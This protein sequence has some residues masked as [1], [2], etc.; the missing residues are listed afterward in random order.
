MNPFMAT[1]F[2]DSCTFDPAGEPDN[3]CS[4]EIFSYYQK[5]EINLIVSH[6]STKEA[7]YPNI[8]S[9]IKSEAKLSG[10]DVTLTTEENEKKNTIWNI[11][12]DSQNPEDMK[13]D[14]E[15]VFEAHKCGG[16]FVTNDSRI[17]KNRKAL[18]NV[19][20][21]LIVTPCELI[22]IINKH[23]NI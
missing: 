16:Y 18:I 22:G 6:S 7:A 23:K 12:A 8:P 21:A 3:S 13:Q 4:E 1:V 9:R 5:D 10:K 2:I 11:I 17:I 14:S 15:H 19:C 20:N